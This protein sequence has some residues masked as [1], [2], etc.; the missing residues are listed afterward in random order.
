VRGAAVEAGSVV[1]DEDRTAPSVTDRKVDRAGGARHERDDCRLVALTDDPQRPV[2][3][4]N[5]EVIDVPVTGFADSQPV[6]AE[7][8]GEG[9]VLSIDPLGREHETAEL[10]ADHPVASGTR[11]DE[12]AFG[13]HVQAS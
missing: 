13:P 7:Q 1:T 11:A 8:R 4:I 10:A 9:G 12:P 2:S 3:A 6:E 5:A